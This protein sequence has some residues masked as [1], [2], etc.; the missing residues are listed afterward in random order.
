MRKVGE[1]GNRH[2]YR[3]SCEDFTI[4]YENLTCTH[5]RILTLAK[6]MCRLLFCACQNVHRI[7]LFS[8]LVQCLL[9]KLNWAGVGALH[10][11]P[12][13]CPSSTTNGQAVLEVRDEE[14]DGSRLGIASL[15]SRR[16]RES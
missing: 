4:T 6:R 13:F 15:G 10:A 9:A 7:L 1:L 3:D 16:G 14:C 11:P 2:N 12:L 8:P 5:D